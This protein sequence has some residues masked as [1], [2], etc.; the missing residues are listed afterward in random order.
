MHTLE[1]SLEKL[2]HA[3]HSTL[4]SATVDQVPLPYRE[5]EGG[6]EDN[7]MQD[8]ARDGGAMMTQESEEESA[9]EAAESVQFSDA[10][11]PVVQR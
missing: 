9:A 4:H 5:G 10:D 3:L 1:I 11:H 8:D 6:E 7:A 2:R